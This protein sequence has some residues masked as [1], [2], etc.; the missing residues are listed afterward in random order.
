MRVAPILYMEHLTDEQI[1]EYECSDRIWLH[2][3]EF[4]HWLSEP[5]VVS[6]LRLTNGVEQFAIGSVYNVHYN[7]PEVIYIPSW[8]CARLTED[9]TVQIER[10]QPSLCTGLTLQP[11]TSDHLTLEDPVTVLRD[12]FENYSCLMPGMEIPLWIGSKM[13][14]TISELQP[15]AN[16]P[17]CIRNCELEIDLLP[18]YDLAIQEF[19]EKEPAN[20]ILHTKI[21]P[22]E[23]VSNEIVSNEIVSNEIVSNEVPKSEGIVLG[24]SVSNKTRREL[25][26]EAALR[27]MNPAKN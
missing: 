14:V 3:E 27:R 5:G 18:P 13:Y 8:M 25:A 23:I 24:G 9:D 7:D 15:I 26:A 6:I 19:T 22:N 1:S 11:H 4:E 12:A 16:T 21:V 17:L 20:T 10:F 2:Q